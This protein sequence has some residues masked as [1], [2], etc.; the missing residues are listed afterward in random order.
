MAVEF[1]GS[2][3]QK[4]YW[5]SFDALDRCNLNA[6]CWFEAL[7]VDDCHHL[8]NDKK[9][10]TVTSIESVRTDVT[11]A[12]QVYTQKPAPRERSS[13]RAQ[14]S[15]LKV[16]KER[17]SKVH[18]ILDS[19][20]ELLDDR[21]A[22]VPIELQQLVFFNRRCSGGLEKCNSN[23]PI[24]GP[25]Y[26]CSTCAT[27]FC[28]QC[29][30]THTPEHAL[31]LHRV[32]A[33]SDAATSKSKWSVQSIIGHTDKKSGRQ[34]IVQWDGP[35]KASAHYKSE[36]NNDTIINEYESGIKKKSGRQRGKHSRNDDSLKAKR[37]R[38]GFAP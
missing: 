6:S 32:V 7:H 9:A 30:L 27:D 19:C 38:I 34:Y 25:M 31:V 16:F 1:E 18:G 12:L 36:L 29:Y 28:A 4:K 22:E 26:S 37:L 5:P 14:A 2:N 35:W 11:A 10:A 21:V 24:Y 3:F 17:V 20:M 8:Q 33:R 15:N 13:K 23:E